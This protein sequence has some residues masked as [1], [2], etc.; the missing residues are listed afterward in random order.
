MTDD[1]PH[2]LGGLYGKFFVPC[3]RCAFPVAP[4]HNAGLCAGCFEL[5]AIAREDA[6]DRRFMVIL[7]AVLILFSVALA[8]TLWLML[9]KGGGS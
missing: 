4:G 3:R 6:E 2:P 5:R 1:T 9:Q 7:T 8:L